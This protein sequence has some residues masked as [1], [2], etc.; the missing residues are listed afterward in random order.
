MK[1]QLLLVLFMSVLV[2]S[3]LSFVMAKDNDNDDNDEEEKEIEK[4][5][6]ELKKIES[7]QKRKVEVKLEGDKVEIESKFEKEDALGE[8]ENKFKIEFETGEE[9]EIKL[10]YEQ[11]SETAEGEFETELEQE[12]EFDSIIEFV[13][14]N[15]N[16]IF[17]KGEEV[18]VYS[19]D[20]RSFNP[21]SYT[22]G[23]TVNNVTEHIISTQTT[24]GVLKITLHA[25]GE[26]ANIENQLVKPT[27]IKID[28]EIN[29]F[30]YTNDSSKLAMKIKIESTMEI[31]T[32][33]RAEG[34]E[35]EVKIK[36]TSNFEGFFSWKKT[37]L[38]DGVEKE[39]LSTSLEQDPDED[40]E[41]IYLIY[42]RG[43]SII[44]DPKIGFTIPSIAIPSF[45]YLV[46]IGLAIVGF[47]IFR[48][49]KK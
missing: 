26:F 16:S 23:I 43:N 4:E 17:D 19:L 35:E 18:F 38:I 40:S 29:N 5:I 25:V 3:T 12:V 6:E 24:D 42:E 2:L 28:L 47:V 10:E 45:I 22:T 21:I 7:G 37:A 44:H 34:G 33:K 13:D 48:L 46:L 31:E 41:E 1:I 32:E 14:S 27:E 20:R 9:V 49:V 39:V 15:N 8:I 36:S 11:E 30:P